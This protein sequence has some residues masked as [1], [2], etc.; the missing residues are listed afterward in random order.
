[1]EL[2]NKFDGFIRNEIES[3]LLK[4]SV[5]FASSLNNIKL[6]WLAKGINLIKSQFCSGICSN[7]LKRN[8]LG[9]CCK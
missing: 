1:M 7:G 5:A 9:F 3:N 2:F 8:F 4:R 6:I